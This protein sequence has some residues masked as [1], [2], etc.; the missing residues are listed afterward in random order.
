MV[1]GGHRDGRSVNVAA[2]TDKLFDRAKG[3]RTVFAGNCVGASHV[4]VHYN[5]KL[6][7]LPLLGQL[8]VNAGMV[9]SEGTYANHR[10]IDGLISDQRSG[11]GAAGCRDLDCK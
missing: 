5:V 9:A 6:D 2:G 4:R 11:L 3:A 8:M 7:R 10:N 1:N